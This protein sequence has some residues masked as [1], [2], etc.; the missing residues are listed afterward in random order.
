MLWSVFNNLKNSSTRCEVAA[1]LVGMLPKGGVH[2]GVDNDATVGKG[3][4]IIEHQRKRKQATLRN[5]KGELILGGTQHYCI[6]SPLSKE[7]GAP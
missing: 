2:L 5:E 7:N 4:K 3:T 6:R 1:T